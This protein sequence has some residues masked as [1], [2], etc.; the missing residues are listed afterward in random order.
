MPYSVLRAQLKDVGLRESP[1]C[2][3][4]L[5]S[6]M[7]SK[8]IHEVYERWWAGPE[9][10][11]A[12]WPAQMPARAASTV[13]ELL[14][15]IA[16][17]DRPAD[18]PADVECH[19]GDVLVFL[20]G[21]GGIT[22]AIKE[23]TQLI[24]AEPEMGRIADALELLPLYGELPAA[25][26]SRALRPESRRRGTRYRVIFATNPGG[27]LADHR[28][29]PPRRGHRSDQPL[30]LGSG[31]R[32][33]VDRTGT[34]FSARAAAAARPGRP[35]RP[36][37]LALPLHRAAVHRAG[38]RDPAGD[39]PGAAAPP[40]CWLPPS[41]GCPTPLRCAGRARDEHGDPPPVGRQLAITPTKP[42]AP[43]TRGDGPAYLFN[44]ADLETCSPHPQGR[45]LV[46]LS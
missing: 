19:Q 20:T 34:A 11:V 12:S 9:L 16:T 27:D 13:V 8:V 35:D 36:G 23:T 7:R 6:R 32:H 18:I 17:G 21:R 40:C 24:G 28:R 37:D 22:T 42:R 45:H 33:R 26:R 25:Q 30:L 1:A 46:G 29:H 3:D 39:R 43:R 10:P 15:W 2:G 44:P 31:N 41:P 38:N 5:V 4:V 14:R